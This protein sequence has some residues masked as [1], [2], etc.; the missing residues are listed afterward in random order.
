M[1]QNNL[2]ISCVITEYFLFFMQLPMFYG[3]IF[4]NPFQFYEEPYNYYIIFVKNI[5][6]VLLF[7]FSSG[8]STIFAVELVLAIDNIK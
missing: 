3:K 2:T 8:K 5:L 1:Q 6:F 7:S 4:S